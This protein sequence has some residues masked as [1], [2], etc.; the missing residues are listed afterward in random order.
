MHHAFADVS[1]DARRRT[2][3]R[4]PALDAT[5][6]ASSRTLARVGRCPP[7]S[8]AMGSARSGLKLFQHEP[9]FWSAGDR[10]HLTLEWEHEPA[11]RDAL[12]PLGL[13]SLVGCQIGAVHVELGDETLLAHLYGPLV[14]LLVEPDDPFEHLDRGHFELAARIEASVRAAG[15]EHAV[16]ARPSD[17]D[18]SRAEP[19]RAEPRAQSV[20]DPTAAP[21]WLVEVVAPREVRALARLGPRGG[22]LPSAEIVP[23]TRIVDA[24]SEALGALA[25][26]DLAVGRL[27]TGRLSDDMIGM[28]ALE[29]AR[30]D[31]DAGAIA[32]VERWVDALASIGRDPGVGPAAAVRA[33]ALGASLDAPDAPDVARELDLTLDA[34]TIELLRAR[35]STGWDSVGAIVDGMLASMRD[36][37]VPCL[38]SARR[39][40]ESAVAQAR[41]GA[42][43]EDVE[44]ALV[45]ETSDWI[46][47][48]LAAV[49]DPRRVVPI[50]LATQD[51]VYLAALTPGERDRLAAA[52]VLGRR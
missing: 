3:E 22:S 45:A 37:G 2:A 34:R 51:S 24:R 29:L 47:R 1:G 40:R 50:T 14:T 4:E 16:R 5:N 49:D 23:E 46:D 10:L 43:F 33:A 15:V 17:D 27:A 13:G 7:S 35:P 19:R 21:R 42:A 6:R 32:R 28:V 36:L 12:A 9:P 26:G 11:M 48:G 20:P 44:R 41:G 31:I 52:G 25:P 30:L 38:G 39:L 8:R 18:V